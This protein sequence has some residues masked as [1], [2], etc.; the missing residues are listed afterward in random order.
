MVFY[1][2]RTRHKSTHPLPGPC[3]HCGTEGSV[4]LD[5]HQRYAHVFWIPVVPLGRVAGTECT[6]CKE[7]R[8]AKEMHPATQLLAKDL[9]KEDRTPVWMFS[10]VI[11]IGLLIP[12]AFWQ[13]GRNDVAVR[14]K[15]QAPLV[16]DVYEIDL[17]DGGYTLYKVTAVTG[18]SVT[19]LLCN[20]ETNKLRGLYTLEAE[21]DAAYSDEQAAF[22]LADLQRMRDEGVVF[23]VKRE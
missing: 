2:T 11:V 20:S 12:W 22:S 18:D 6:H 14:A 19:V 1:G 5:I 15:L 16:G 8:R 13:S 10:G 3:P 21:G 9:L 7:V 23:S 17:V 4:E